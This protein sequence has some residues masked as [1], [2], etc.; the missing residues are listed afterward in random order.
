MVREPSLSFVSLQDE[1]L[2]DESDGIPGDDTI[3]K[4]PFMLPE[5]PILAW[6]YRPDHVAKTNFLVADG[7]HV[8]LTVSHSHFRTFTSMMN[9]QI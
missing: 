1:T 7:R 5:I 9:R 2:D 3:F 6:F 4:F 8:S